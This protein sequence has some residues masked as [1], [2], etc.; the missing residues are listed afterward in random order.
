MF[1]WWDMPTIP[2]LSRKVREV[3]LRK[4]ECVSVLWNWNRDFMSNQRK[5]YPGW[6]QENVSFPAPNCWWRTCQH[7]E[8]TLSL[9]ILNSDLRLVSPANSLKPVA[10]SGEEGGGEQPSQQGGFQS[11]LQNTPPGGTLGKSLDHTVPYFLI[12]KVGGI[13]EPISKGCSEG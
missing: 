8:V 10:S 13:T 12:C 4:V 7:K 3:G 6:S 9:V 2:W 1:F 11:W 5:L